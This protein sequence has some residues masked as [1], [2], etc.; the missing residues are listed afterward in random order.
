MQHIDPLRNASDVWM[1]N[2][3]R[4]HNRKLSR[5]CQPQLPGGQQGH[6]EF[7]RNGCITLQCHRQGRS[8]CWAGKPALHVN[9]TPTGPKLPIHLLE[10][11][12]WRSSSWTS[13]T[14]HHNCHHRCSLKTTTAYVT[15]HAHLL[16]PCEKQQACSQQ[17]AWHEAW[18]D[19]LGV[20]KLST[21]P[22]QL[23]TAVH[24]VP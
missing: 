24:T 18:F 17:Q 11:V 5:P 19:C 22:V 13:A 7:G 8:S 16:Q 9:I 4:V 3:A 14:N 15:I 1:L 12:S 10:A 21:L 20:G 23:E 2:K 6:G